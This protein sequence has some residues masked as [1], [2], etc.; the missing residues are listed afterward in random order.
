MT[1]GQIEYRQ[2]L[3]S[4]RWRLIRSTRRMWDGNRCRMCKSKEGLQV[5]HSSY[6]HRGEPWL[7]I[8]WEW[9]D[10]ITVCDFHHKAAHNGMNIK[11]F[12]D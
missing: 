8:L 5:H 12:A 7:G 10:C 9:M 2:Y 1:A 6:L 4:W 3:D 11:E